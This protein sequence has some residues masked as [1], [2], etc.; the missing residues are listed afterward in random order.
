MSY[1]EDTYQDFPC[2]FI[3]SVTSSY[4]VSHHHTRTSLVSSYIVSHHHTQ[5]H[6]IIPGLPLS[7]HTQCHIII[8]SV[9]SS[10]Q[11]FP[12]QFADSNILVHAGEIDK[13]PRLL[14]L[15]SLQ[16]TGLSQQSTSSLLCRLVP[17]PPLSTPALPAPAA[18][19]AASECV[20]SRVL[21]LCE[22]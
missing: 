6:I 5:C 22:A 10:Y 18:A 19:R 21:A 8:H 3:H 16:L 2:Q 4:T 17:P 14:F 20:H 15:L 7:V 1:E 11:D 12:R 13:M 9:T